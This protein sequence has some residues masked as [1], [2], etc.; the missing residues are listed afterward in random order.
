MS[1]ASTSRSTRAIRTN[2][3]TY[4]STGK[5]AGRNSGWTQSGK[6]DRKVSPLQNGPRSGGS[7]SRIATISSKS[8]IAISPRIDEEMQA[9]AVRFTDDFLELTLADGRRVSTPLSFYPSLLAASKRQRED[10]AF[11]ADATALEWESLDLQ[12][13]VDSIVCG[14][15]EHVPPAGFREWVRERMAAEK[16]KSRVAR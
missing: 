14:R 13:S 5:A 3:A 6:R 8:G 12:L 9:V 1:K 11:I 7:S 15:R 16:A 2:R 4:T 10:F